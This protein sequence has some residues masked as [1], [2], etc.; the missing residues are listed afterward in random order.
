MLK[1][2][3]KF[4]YRDKEYMQFVLNERPD[5]GDIER[6][7]KRL[8]EYNRPFFEIQDEYQ[9]VLEAAEQ[10]G[11]AGGIVFTVKGEWLDI[12]FLWVDEAKRESGLGSALLEKAEQKGREKGCKTAYLTTFNFQARPFYE[13][14]G[15]NVV[16]TQ[17]NYPITN[18]RYHM[19]KR[20]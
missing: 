13:K 16:Y 20:L 8:Q 19:E 3:A 15:Y 12:D 2:L 9:Y 14:R 6:V 4:Q 11:L 1:S 17:K 5:S 18:E 7:R 10:G